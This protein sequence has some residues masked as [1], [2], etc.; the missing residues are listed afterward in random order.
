[1]GCNL[2]RFG[3]GFNFVFCEIEYRF[4]IFVLSG[5]YFCWLIVFIK[6]F[7]GGLLYLFCMYREVC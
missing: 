1:M 7:F 2:V 6:V 4:L 5:V 3:L